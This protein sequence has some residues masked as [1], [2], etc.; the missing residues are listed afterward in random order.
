VRT[1]AIIVGAG[2][3]G[4][5]M[6]RCLSDRAIVHVVLER[7]R[8]AERWRS[9]RWESLRLLTP[10]W[11]TRLPGFTYSGPDPDGYMNM[12]EVVAFLEGYA[13]SQP[14]PIEPDTAVREIAPDAA[15][16][17]LSTSRGIWLAPVVIL[18]TGYCDEPLVPSIASRLP[19]DV[20]QVVP[21]HYR[22]PEDLPDGGVLVVGAS[23][24]G[25]Q[26]AEEIHLSGRPVTLA[27]GHHTRV[28]RSYR[29]RDIMWWLDASGVLG[30]TIEEVFD[31]AVSRQQPSFQLIGRPGAPLD[32]PALARLG[33]RVVGRLVDATAGEL[34]FADDLVAT[35]A[36]ADVKL[37]GLLARLDAFARSARIEA[38]PDGAFEPSWPRFV[39]AATRIGLR[40]S[41][42]RT[43][44]WAT[45]FRRNYSWLKVPVLDARGEIRHRGGVTSQPGLFA[46]GLPFLRRRNSNFI[47]G[48]GAD[49]HVLAAAVA[50]RLAARR[51]A[52]A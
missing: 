6:S 7:G 26:L 28:P 16:F 19:A 15:G 22:R 33:V 1:D 51:R 31:V 3:A 24:T 47:D 44:L 32:L 48:V 5:A 9:E 49:A 45:G 25:I 29:G 20:H 2:Q 42:I 18:A 17:R 52:F 10:N 14:A 13:R 40:E 36:A 50:T 4:L 39:D 21:T 37:A 11:Q 27:A 34:R 35:T 41:G 12:R 38:A 46:I 23:A 8:V 30:E 43:I